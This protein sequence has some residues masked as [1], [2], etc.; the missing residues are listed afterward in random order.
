MSRVAKSMGSNFRINR[1]WAGITFAGGALLE[2]IIE[3]IK[4]SNKKK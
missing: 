3:E 2:T 1:G 4:K